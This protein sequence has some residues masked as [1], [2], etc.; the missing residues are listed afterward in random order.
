MKL[1]KFKQIIIITVF[2]SITTSSLA[3]VELPTPPTGMNSIQVNYLDHAWQ[4]PDFEI[5]KFDRLFIKIDEFEYRPTKKTIQNSSKKSY[6]LNDKAKVKLKNNT[7]KTF[8]A[9]LRHLDNF[10]II[11]MKDINKNTLFIKITLK[12]I[13][14]YIPDT[15]QKLYQTKLYLRE[16]GEMTLDIEIINSQ[17]SKLLF[18][19]LVREKIKTTGNQLGSANAIRAT[20]KTK[21]ILKHWAKELSNYINEIDS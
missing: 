1:S 12:D 7:L 5:K 10:T 13:V 21:I 4:S 19:G 6:E 9:E 16:M 18:K 3:E 11:D 20:H 14:N 2:C 17:N 15:H 8:T